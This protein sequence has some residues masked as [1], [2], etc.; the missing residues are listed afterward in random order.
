MAQ[1]YVIKDVKKGKVWDSS[2]GQ[3]QAYALALED[4]GEPVKMN[5][6]M[7]VA[8]EPKPGDTIFGSLEEK[9]YDGRVF[10]NFKSEKH[11]FQPK[12]QPRDDKAIRAQWAIDQAV[13]IGM[14]T[15]QLDDS[16]IEVK[17]IELFKMVGRV[18]ES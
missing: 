15:N 9:E 14:A 8:H 13:Q 18:K 7:P 3:M 2:Y 1:Q 12:G 16:A 6:K 17:A 4:V 11:P 10:F 5:K